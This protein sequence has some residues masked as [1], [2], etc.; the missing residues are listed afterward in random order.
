MADQHGR[1]AVFQ[2]RSSKDDDV[3]IAHSSSGLNTVAKFG[4][5]INQF[6]SRA[7]F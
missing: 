4:K 5:L 1:E 2:S 3:S 6:V 7:C